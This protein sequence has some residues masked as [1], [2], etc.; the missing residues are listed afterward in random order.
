MNPC[1]VGHRDYRGRTNDTEFT[2]LIQCY[3][4]ELKILQNLKF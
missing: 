3:S 1:G 4:K 2:G